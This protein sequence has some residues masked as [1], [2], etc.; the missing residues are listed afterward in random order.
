MLSLIVEEED[1]QSV[2]LP[3]SCELI[4]EF[5]ACASERRGLSLLLS[6]LSL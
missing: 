5:A 2:L 6:M 4:S 3:S 1:L